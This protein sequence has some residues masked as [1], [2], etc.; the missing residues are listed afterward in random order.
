MCI[1]IS[2]SG[3]GCPV[4]DLQLHARPVNAALEVESS[5]SSYALHGHCLNGE[6]LDNRVALWVSTAATLP[7]AACG[8][9]LGSGL[10][11]SRKS[12]APKH[13]GSIW[14]PQF[15]AMLLQEAPPS[16]LSGG[17]SYAPSPT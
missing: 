3:S 13:R 1:C 5:G 12:D 11:A 6:A 10:V 2:M 16:I 15:V 7:V 9:V 17:A 14:P 4:E 8:K